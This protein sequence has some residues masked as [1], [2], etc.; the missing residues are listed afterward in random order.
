MRANRSP[1]QLHG[2][3]PFKYQFVSHS[4]YDNVL[5]WV[6]EEIASSLSCHALLLRVSQEFSKT[7]CR[8]KK[9]SLVAR[10]VDRGPPASVETHSAK[11]SPSLF[12]RF[13]QK[14]ALTKRLIS[15]WTSFVAH[16]QRRGTMSVVFGSADAVCEI[17]MQG[18]WRH[19]VSTYLNGYDRNKLVCIFLHALKIVKGT[20]LSSVALIAFISA[21]RKWT[22]DAIF[23]FVKRLKTNMDNKEVCPLLIQIQGNFVRVFATV[24]MG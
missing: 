2:L 8:G 1:M 12:P 21:V 10:V 14:S 4:F 24:Q 9:E 3:K 17:F 7:P 20:Y 11:R 19:A 13:S 5:L 15:S 18:Q 23:L 16:G 6:P 22:S